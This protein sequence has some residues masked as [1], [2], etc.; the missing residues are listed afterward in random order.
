MCGHC[1]KGLPSFTPLLGHF[2]QIGSP[3]IQ[4]QSFILFVGSPL[5]KLLIFREIEVIDFYK[6][7]KKQ[8]TALTHPN[9]PPKNPLDPVIFFSASWIRASPFASLSAI[10][11]KFFDNDLL[12]YFFNFLREIVS[13]TPK[14]KWSICE[15]T[16]ANC[17]KRKL[18]TVGKPRDGFSFGTVHERLWTLKSKAKN[19]MEKPSNWE[20]D[21]TWQLSYSLE[22]RTFYI[23]IIR[24]LFL[25]SFDNKE[26]IRYL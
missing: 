22:G 10:F 13:Y 1:Y 23:F 24:T 25:I 16:L 6:I 26:G 5:K 2:I 14:E 8:E 3:A 20:R 11:T 9:R 7:K 21:L 18:Q 4:F 12:F 15:E 19:C 17:L